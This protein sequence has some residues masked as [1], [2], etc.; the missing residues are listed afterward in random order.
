MRT[1]AIE[2][3][4]D[5]TSVGII[6]F[7]GSTFTVDHLAAE[8]QVKKHQPYGGVVPE[9]ASRE[10]ADAIL[11]VLDHIV[12]QALQKEGEL[13]PQD[14]ITFF[15]TIDFI[16]YTDH[17]GLPGALLVG[18]TVAKTLATHFAKPCIPVNH[19]HGHIFSLLLER[20]TADIAFP[21][22]VLTASG[23]HN[24]IYIIETNPPQH[25]LIRAGEQTLPN[26][27]DTTTL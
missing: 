17:P 2:T 9:L 16:S 27:T 5:D 24:D 4:C 19:I 11:V 22:A 10:H 15:A 12:H 18:K 1:L 6:S 3:S 7:D 8:S 20:N 21:L 25:S 14:W 23:G 26:N 13:S